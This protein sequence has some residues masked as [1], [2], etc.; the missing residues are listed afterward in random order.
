MYMRNINNRGWAVVLV[1]C[2]QDCIMNDRPEN[3]TTHPKFGEKP[4]VLS[5]HLVSFNT[6]YL[7]VYKKHN[8]LTV[9]GWNPGY[10]V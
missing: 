2:L 3:Y 8:H 9:W 4:T 7:G 1:G 5:V 10:N 6:K